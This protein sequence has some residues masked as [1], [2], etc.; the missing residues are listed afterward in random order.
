MECLINGYT[1]QYILAKVSTAEEHIQYMCI[2]IDK[3]YWNQVADKNTHNQVPDKIPH[4][5]VADKIPHNQV[6]HKIPHLNVADKIPHH[7]VAD[8]I[9]TIRWLIRPPRGLYYTILEAF[10]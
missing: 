6:S 10:H 8:M 3:N 9:P 1:V 5:Q 4:L 2:H 7:Q